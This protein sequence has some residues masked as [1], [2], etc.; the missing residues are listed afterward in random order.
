MDMEESLRWKIRNLK[1]ESPN[2]WLNDEGRSPLPLAV[3]QRYWSTAL[4]NRKRQSLR[5]S[6]FGHLVIGV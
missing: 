2:Q 3:S 1:S 4:R 6:S 5:D